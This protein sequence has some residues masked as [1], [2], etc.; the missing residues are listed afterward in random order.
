MQGW[1]QGKEMACKIFTNTG[2]PLHIFPM[3][4]PHGLGLLTEVQWAQLNALLRSLFPD[5][6]FSELI[7]ML[8]WITT[9]LCRWCV[10]QQGAPAGSSVC[11]GEGISSL[12]ELPLPEGNSFILH[13]KV[14]LTPP[15]PHRLLY[16]LW[17][18]VDQPE[19]PCFDG[20]LKACCEI[21]TAPHAHRSG[22]CES[23]PWRAH[24]AVR[25]VFL[26]NVHKYTWIM[27]DDW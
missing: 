6:F 22:C 26:H 13:I 1:A 17:F 12:T 21:T 15:V 20:C 14:Q 19:F 8:L 11:P 7:R 16:R 4:P 3:P 18:Q 9:R 27:R 25:C 10:Q 24:K 5:S 2:C 23:P